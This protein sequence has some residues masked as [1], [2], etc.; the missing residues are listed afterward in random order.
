MSKRYTQVPLSYLEPIFEEWCRSFSD[1]CV[2]SVFF[3]PCSD[4]LQRAMQYVDWMLEKRGEK[5][6]LLNMETDMISSS[7]DLRTDLD[8]NKNRKILLLA[9]KAFMNPEVSA[10]SGVIQEWYARYGGGM[11]IFHE[12]F[13]GELSEYAKKSTLMQRQIIHRLYP[14][15]VVIEFNKAVAK[16]NNDNIDESFLDNL[17]TYCGGVLWLHKDVLR[18]VKEGGD[19]YTNELF[20][21]KVAQIMK[22]IPNINGI[23]HELIQF[24]LKDDQGN[25]LPVFADYM[26]RKAENTLRITRDYI[27]YD[28]RDYSSN[29]SRGERKI[30][31]KLRQGD[32]V[33]SREELGKLFW[34]EDVEKEYSDWALDAI[35]SRLRKKL[36]KIGIP[37]VI[38]TR[39]GRGYEGK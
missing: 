37:I 36:R 4:L 18:R 30:L 34:D 16:L 9:K 10:L 17:A 29:F 8:K 2:T 1:N 31:E 19:L 5:V 12:G 21:W 32:Q 23:E 6:V 11:L 35:M 3:P 22:S 38:T 20:S 33:V 25:W 39:R 28:G 27:G 15:S 7:E 24:G 26:L 14:K 13:P